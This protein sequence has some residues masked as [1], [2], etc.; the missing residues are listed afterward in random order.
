MQIELLR[1]NVFNS[2]TFNLISSKNQAK[3]RFELPSKQSFSIK[4]FNIHFCNRT[5]HPLLTMQLKRMKKKILKK[6]MYVYSSFEVK[7]K[8]N[9][10]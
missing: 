3:S 2:H 4:A 7:N 8:K 9:S 10:K 1:M 6:K 5:V